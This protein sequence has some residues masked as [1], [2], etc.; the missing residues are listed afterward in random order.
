MKD[1]L[2]VGALSLKKV[3]NVFIAAGENDL[4]VP[5]DA[6]KYFHESVQPMNKHF[7]PVPKAGHDLMCNE[8]SS[9]LVNKALY[10]WI[11]TCLNDI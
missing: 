2:K 8:S 6:I 5:L 11:S 9:R 7:M 1:D 3:H 10:D 4:A